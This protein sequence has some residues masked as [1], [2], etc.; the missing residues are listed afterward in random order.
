MQAPAMAVATV[1]GTALT[2]PHTTVRGDTFR[3][4]RTIAATTG[5]I[6]TTIG[7]MDI[8]ATM[9][10]MVTMAITVTA[11]ACISRLVSRWI[12]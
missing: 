11:A 7:I 6:T 2:I 8:T 5:S 9:A 12:V 3:E 1:M 4:C 10:I